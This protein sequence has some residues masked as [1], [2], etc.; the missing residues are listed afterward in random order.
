LGATLVVYAVNF[1][2]LGFLLGPY[3]YDHLAGYYELAARFWRSGTWLPHFNPLLCGGRTLAGDPQLPIFSPLVVLVPIVG[4]VWLPKLEMLAQLAIGAYGLRRWLSF[5]RFGTE[6]ID[7]ATL[8]FIA[9]GAVTARFLVGHVTL[10]YYFLLPAFF[11]LSE[12]LAATP[13]REAGKLFP[14]YGALFT[15]SALYKPNFIIYF[16]PPLV[17]EHFARAWFTKNPRVVV[18]LVGALTVMSG[19]VA[20]SYIPAGLYFKAFPRLDDFAHA[21]PLHTLVANL[22]MPLRTLPNSWY[23]PHFFQRHEYTQFIGPVALY[24]A[25]R[26]WQRWP[27]EFSAQKKSLLV[28][29]LFSTALGMGSNDLQFHLERPFSWFVAWWPG[30]RN[31]RVPPRFWFGVSFALI[32]FAAAGWEAPKNRWRAATVKALLILPLFLSAAYTLSRTTIEAPHSQWSVPRLFPATMSWTA[33]DQMHSYPILREGKGVLN[34]LY[35][36]ECRQS[37]AVVPGDNLSI[38]PVTETVARRWED[39]NTIALEAG[40]ASPERFSLNLN[41]APGWTFVG[42]G[43]RIVSGEHERLTLERAP[44]GA[45]GRLVYT[46]AGLIPAAWISAIT[47]LLCLSAVAIGAGRRFR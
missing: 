27:A 42:E 32:A 41:H 15:Y 39:W 11:Y 34:C 16:V 12:R 36:L 29:L 7:V 35:N 31:I 19:L 28:F 24:F 38:L 22:I 3:D 43:A 8:L 5:F 13:W 10:G 46:Q 21:V 9:G 30:F 2:L 47:A 18:Y 23:G 6:A 4:A 37:P 17:I 44:T 20:V 14:I 45:R 33:G 40:P 25:L 26:G 1:G